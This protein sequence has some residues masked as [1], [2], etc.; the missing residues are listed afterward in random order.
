M[1]PP[2]RA[3]PS[4]RTSRRGSARGV[5]PESLAGPLAP[6]LVG[7]PSKDAR[8]NRVVNRFARA[9]RILPLTDTSM[10][11][12]ASRPP[13]RPRTRRN[14]RMQ[15]GQLDPRPR[16]QEPVMSG[17]ELDVVA[18]MPSR[19]TKTEPSGAELARQRIEAAERYAAT[20]RTISR[21][22]TKSELKQLEQQ[23]WT[24]KMI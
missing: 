16:S 14:G 9:K 5:R 23:A 20:R 13:E 21:T 24:K 3:P 17:L 19:A 22:L 4:R 15:T 1:R 6:P 8:A 2:R 18:P 11:G 10:E 7:R 12:R